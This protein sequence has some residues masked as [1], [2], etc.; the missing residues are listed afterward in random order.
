MNFFVYWKNKEGKEEIITA[1]TNGLILPG[2]TRK[3]VISLLKE[4]GYTVTE[5][6]YKLK[7]VLDAIKEKRVKEVFGTGTA[8]A[9]VPVKSLTYENVEYKMPY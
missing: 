4:K 2:I 3:S 5:R 7:E 8:A 6:S 9:V 1:P